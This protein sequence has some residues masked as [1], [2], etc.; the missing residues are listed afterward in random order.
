MSSLLFSTLNISCHFLLAY[1]VSVDRSS[2]NHMGFFLYVICCFSLAAFN[3]I[4]L[5]LVFVSLI[6]IC[7]SIFLLG[8]VPLCAS[9]TWL[10]ISF[11][12]DI[13]DY[14]IRSD[15]ISRS[16]VSDS[17][18]LL[19][20]KKKRSEKIFEETIEAVYCHH[21]YLTYTQSTSWETLDWKKHKLESRLPGEISITSDMQ[22]T[23][24]LWQKV[25]RNSKA[26]WWK[27][28]D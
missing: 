16:V 27:C 19:E 11:V 21:V 6:S 3:I 23:P 17:F 14:Q 24:P 25:K 9:W 20:E 10:T 5:C 12:G 26:S 15:Q 8:F 18:R 1:R 22:M 28:Y 2:I 4:S 7:L 13:F